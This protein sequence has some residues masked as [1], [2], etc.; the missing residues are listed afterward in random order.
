MSIIGILETIWDTKMDKLEKLGNLKAI[1]MLL[2][3][4]K[5]PLTSGDVQKIN[6]FVLIFS[7]SI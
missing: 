5:I 3:R 6:E 2:G 4:R 7:G 1:Y